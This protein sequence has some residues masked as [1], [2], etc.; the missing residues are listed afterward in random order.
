[1]LT[2]LNLDSLK[3][4]PLGSKSAGGVGDKGVANDVAE[5]TWGKKK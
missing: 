3:L 2:S 4:M 5:Q 1:M